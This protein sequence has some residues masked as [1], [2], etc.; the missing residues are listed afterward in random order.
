MRN[1]V[2]HATRNLSRGNVGSTARNNSAKVG[3]QL[4]KFLSKHGFFCLSQ[5]LQSRFFNH[6]W[7]LKT[8]L[9]KT[10]LDMVVQPAVAQ[11]QIRGVRRLM[12][13]LHLSHSKKLLHRLLNIWS[14]VVLLPHQL[15]EMYWIAFQSTPLV[16]RTLNELGVQVTIKAPSV[17]QCSNAEAFVASESNYQHAFLRRQLAGRNLWSGCTNWY[18][19]P[20]IPLR[21]FYVV[22]NPHLVLNSVDVVPLLT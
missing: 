22:S 9:T 14:S 21:E 11:I 20:S 18:P 17:W 19:S 5:A 1:C 10:V 2:L 8:H 7:V 12:K 16:A 3:D 6:H 13:E 4:V 15:L